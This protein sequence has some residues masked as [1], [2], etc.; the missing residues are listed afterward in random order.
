M[1]KNIVLKDSMGVEQTYQEVS[2][3]I[4]KDDEG[5]D[6]EFAEGG[7]ASK[8]SAASLI[9]KTIAECIDENSE[10][11][12]IPTGLFSSCLL[13]SRVE[14]PVCL[15]IGM[16]AF[17]GCTLLSEAIFPACTKISGSAFLSC[18]SLSQAV[19]PECS[20][21]GSNAFKSCSSLTKIS[22]PAC[23]NIYSSAF[24]GCFWLSQ[25]IFNGPSIPTLASSNAFIN[26]AM[27][28]STYLGHY[29]SIYVAE[30]MVDAFKTATNWATYADR[31]TS[32]ENLPPLS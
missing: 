29:G 25:A 6:V 27:T 16:D 22:F 20:Y 1:A 24:F 13:L 11:L 23:T 4:L 32:I 30:S 21:I 3:I 5:N 31:I 19:F 9:A 14:F 15:T 7:G 26:T 2:K 17:V 18:N 10:V 8:D 28:I 12:S